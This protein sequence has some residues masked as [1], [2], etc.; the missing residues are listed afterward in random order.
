MLNRFQPALFFARPDFVCVT[1]PDGEEVPP[2]SMRRDNT[3]GS[4]FG[5]AQAR[6][7]VLTQTSSVDD[8]SESGDSVS[9]SSSDDDSDN[10]DAVVA[11]PSLKEKP[12]ASNWLSRRSQREVARHLAKKK[13][14]KKQSK[15]EKKLAKLKVGTYVWTRQEGIADFAPDDPPQKGK[16]RTRV[17]VYGT[18]MKK[19]VYYKDCWV[20]YFDKIDITA[21]CHYKHLHFEAATSKNALHK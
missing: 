20:V 14:A 19:S 15:E 2:P 21:T 13:F 1:Q 10:P 7:A 5:S 16:R 6:P 3:S 12:T 17:K 9:L 8:A 4:L 11:I 18:L